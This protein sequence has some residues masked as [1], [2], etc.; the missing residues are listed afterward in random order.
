MSSLVEIFKLNR[1][2][3]YSKCYIYRMKVS[4]MLLNKSGK[5]RKIPPGEAWQWTVHL[6]DASQLT[7]VWTQL[8]RDIRENRLALANLR[9]ER[10]RLELTSTQEVNFAY[11]GP[12]IFDVRIQPQRI[13]NLHAH[14]AEGGIE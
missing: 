9:V 4:Y 11:K 8:K 7:D 14:T 10:H 12:I 6:E 1:H 5:S 3:I 13:F 2:F